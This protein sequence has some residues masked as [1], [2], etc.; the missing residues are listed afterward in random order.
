MISCNS[1]G[2][3]TC[4]LCCI[5]LYKG[6]LVN[7]EQFHQLQNSGSRNQSLKASQPKVSITS[8]LCL[9]SLVWCTQ[10][11][12]PG[13]VQILQKTWKKNIKLFHESIEKRISRNGVNTGWVNKPNQEL[14]LAFLYYFFFKK[15]ITMTYVLLTIISF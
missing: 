5:S 4:G 7:P 13:R 11:K 8:F 14:S 2:D 9:K 6:T 1:D 12:W 15:E 3:A 10:G